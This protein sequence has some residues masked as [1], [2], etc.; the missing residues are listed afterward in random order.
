MSEINLLP[1]KKRSQLRFGENQKKIL[2]F[3]VAFLVLNVL[4]SSS[5][6][7]YVYYQSEELNKNLKEKASLEKYVESYREKILDLTALHN[8]IQG[9][10]YIIDQQFDY[11]VGIED[12]YTSLPSGISAT[13]LKVNKQGV[14]S[15]RLVAADSAAIFSYLNQIQS[16][17]EKFTSVYF[18]PI[19]RQE[20]DG[21]YDISVEFIFPKIKKT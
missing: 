5:V 1:E 20:K 12:F 15:A 7:T 14:F 8:R 17:P 3:S 19:K 16:N 11:A 4:V 13:D 9:I 21:T 2:L 10:K 18:G 6:W